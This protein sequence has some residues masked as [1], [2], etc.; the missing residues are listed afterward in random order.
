M[1][2]LPATTATIGLPPRKSEIS[3]P[4]RMCAPISSAVPSRTRSVQS[5]APMNRTPSLRTVPGS[6]RWIPDCLSD[7]PRDRNPFLARAVRALGVGFGPPGGI[8]ARSVCSCEDACPA[9]VT[10]EARSALGVVSH[11]VY[12]GSSWRYPKR[13]RRCQMGSGQLPNV[14][15]GLGATPCDADAFDALSCDAVSPPSSIPGSRH[16][17]RHVSARAGRRAAREPRPRGPT[18]RFI[19][20]FHQPAA[21]PVEPAS[22]RLFAGARAGRHPGAARGT[23]ARIVRSHFADGPS[24]SA[25][26]RE[27]GMGQGVDVDRG[28]A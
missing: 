14:R 11:G 10:A 23:C 16:L 24:A 8:E 6:R 25:V 13:Q 19:A 18:T 1:S 22:L 27:H 15:F 5:V 7:H 12:R 4:M 3:R 2:R 9:D 20:P 28:A 17:P 26:H 21:P